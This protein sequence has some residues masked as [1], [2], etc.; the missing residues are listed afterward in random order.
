MSHQTTTRS[1]R[2]AL[3][4]A[5]AA[6]ATLVACGDPAPEDP[7]SDDPA[8]APATADAAETGA[9]IAVLDPWVRVAIRP[10]NA[11]VAEAP[12]VNSAGYLVLRNAGPDAD[13]IVA[14]ETEVAD[15]AELHSVSMDDGVM[16]MRPVDSVAVAAGGQAV[17]EPGGYH[18]MLI[19][20]RRALEE[21]DTVPLTLRLRSGKAVEVRAP[22]LK[23]PPQG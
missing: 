13:A 16:R 20:I 4:L 1:S 5:L 12:P 21:G 10:E 22:V 15:T 6:A 8:A 9:A 17:L 14:V 18:I 3:T 11:D 23:S 2:A 19:G 7:P